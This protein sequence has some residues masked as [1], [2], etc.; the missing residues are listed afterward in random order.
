[1]NMRK[2]FFKLNLLLWYCCVSV[3]HQKQ[4]KKAQLTLPYVSTKYFSSGKDEITALYTARHDKQRALVFSTFL[5]PCKISSVVVN[6][7]QVDFK[8]ALSL[9]R[10]RIQLT[11]DAALSHEIKIIYQDG[12]F[13]KH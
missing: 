6:G 12:C 11:A 7:K 4:W 8:L 1:M 3:I 5:R 13:Q 2:I 9:S 10:I